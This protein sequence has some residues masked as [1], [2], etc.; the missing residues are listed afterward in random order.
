MVLSKN[1]VTK[2]IGLVTLATTRL[3]SDGVEIVCDAA[4]AAA[5]AG[6]C[7]TFQ[8]GRKEKMV[9]NGGTASVFRKDK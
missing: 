1:P 7:K 9:G 5:A 6:V 2:A 8:R 3:N 4:D